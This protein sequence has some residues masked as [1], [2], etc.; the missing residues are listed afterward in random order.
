[1]EEEKFKIQSEYQTVQLA[2]EAELS[3]VRAELR[4]KTYELE[5][6]KLQL[7]EIESNHEDVVDER[8]AL[9]AKF[10]LVK[11]E[12]KERLKMYENL[13]NELESAIDKLDY[14]TLGMMNGPITSD[15]RIKQSL[16]LT[17]TVMELTK[18]NCFSNLH[19]SHNRCLFHYC[20]KSRLRWTLCANS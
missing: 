18:V 1:M 13:E 12:L 10:A 4:V 19:P 7:H 17:R 16:M 20:L 8:D 3:R 15:R 6:L 5:R 9:Q 14:N 11:E 2:N